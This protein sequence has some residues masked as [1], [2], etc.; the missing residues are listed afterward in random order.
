MAVAVVTVAAGT[1]VISN[2]EAS[3]IQVSVKGALTDTL[4][5][6]TFKDAGWQKGE[7]AA[8][9]RAAMHTRLESKLAVHMTGDALAHFRRV[10]DETIEASANGENMVATAGGVSKFEVATM[11]TGTP[12]EAHVTGRVYAWVTH[13]THEDSTDGKGS[14]RTEGWGGFTATVVRVDGTWL[15]SEL[16]Y[17]PE[18]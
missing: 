1:M 3:R 13:V 8:D 15:V 6:A 2:D 18:L 11:E 10:L 9:K 16:D 14:G 12:G 7:L 17:W 5:A 4:D